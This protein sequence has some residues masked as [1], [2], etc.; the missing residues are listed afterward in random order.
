MSEWISVEDELPDEE[1][2]VLL[3]TDEGHPIVGSIAE[4]GI[5]SGNQHVAWDWAV[6]HDINTVTHWAEIPEPPSAKV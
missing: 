5:V 1:K 3:L 4:R 2:L 6:N